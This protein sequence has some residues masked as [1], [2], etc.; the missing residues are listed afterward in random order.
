MRVAL[1]LQA[2]RSVL[3]VDRRRR[4]VA[5]AVAVAVADGVV[6]PVDH[7]LNMLALGPIAGL[8]E[9]LLL[10]VGGVADALGAFL[11]GGPG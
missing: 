7:D 8:L 9:G 10:R 1:L 11:A 3:L 4:V 5:V 2:G 6:R